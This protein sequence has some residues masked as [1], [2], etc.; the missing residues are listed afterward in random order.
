M[1]WVGNFKRKVFYYRKFYLTFLCLRTNNQE[2]TNENLKKKLSNNPV[3][4]GTDVNMN[5]LRQ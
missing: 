3:K 4:T 5:T 1:T 2:L